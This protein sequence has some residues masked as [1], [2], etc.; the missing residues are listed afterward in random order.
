M[1]YAPGEGGEPALSKPQ[2]MDCFC[3]T[4]SESKS[5]VS[6]PNWSV[7]EL[8]GA[9]IESILPDQYGMVLVE[10]NGGRFIPPKNLSVSDR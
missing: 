8:T 7:R 4:I 10:D 5:H 2:G 1:I 9:Q 6:F 3:I